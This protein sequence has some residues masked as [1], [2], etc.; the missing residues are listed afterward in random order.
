ME[1]SE[2]QAIQELEVTNTKADEEIEH[3]KAMA[4]LH[5]KRV[6]TLQTQVKTL[7]SD[8]DNLENAI[9]LCQ[10]SADKRLQV[11]KCDRQNVEAENAQLLTELTRIRQELEVINL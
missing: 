5:Q 3:W 9:A 1:H 2:I 8:K 6:A 10:R 11:L 4:N 7:R